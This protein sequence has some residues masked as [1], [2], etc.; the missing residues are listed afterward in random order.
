MNISVVSETMDDT[1][2]SGGEASETDTRKYLRKVEAI[3]RGRAANT[4][5]DI[6]N[7]YFD[8]LEDNCWFQ[9][10]ANIAILMLLQTHSTFQCCACVIT[11]VSCLRSTASFVYRFR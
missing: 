6:I 11:N 10:R 1:L 9:R 4:R 8:V 5:D 7:E 3:D 2:R